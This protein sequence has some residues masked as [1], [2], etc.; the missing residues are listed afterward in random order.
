MGREG[1]L[2]PPGEGTLAV[3]G[4]YLKDAGWSLQPK[5]EMQ[6][7]EANNLSKFSPF[8]HIGQEISGV[9]E[10]RLF[11][12]LV[13]QR[14]QLAWL[15]VPHYWS[16]ASASGR[17]SIKTPGSAP[18]CESRRTYTGKWIARWGKAADSE[19]A[20]LQRRWDRQVGFC[21]RF[22]LPG[23][24]RA[25]RGEQVRSEG[26]PALQQAPSAPDSD[27]E[28]DAGAQESFAAYQLYD[29]G[30]FYFGTFVFSFCNWNN[31]RI[32]Q[33][34]CEESVKILRTV[35]GTWCKPWIY[36]L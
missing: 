26:T 6:E 9:V 36:S 13:H 24:A 17:N 23:R 11:G 32:S 29:L 33:A 19:E 20:V 15:G 10:A 16:K 21:P 8:F 35:S 28:P 31:S 5:D 12:K 14:P 18:D 7:E 25:A 1:T 4:P 2:A 22:V 3:S 27:R 34:C 30:Q